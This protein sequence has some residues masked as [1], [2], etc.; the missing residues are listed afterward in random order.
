MQMHMESMESVLDELRGDLLNAREHA[1]D[2]ENALHDSQ[3][4]RYAGIPINPQT[5][6]S[7]ASSSCKHSIQ[8]FS[9][10]LN[11]ALARPWVVKSHS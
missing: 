3:T 11:V 5:A 7:M 8:A 6:L 4:K 9:V 1:S 2:L 10:T